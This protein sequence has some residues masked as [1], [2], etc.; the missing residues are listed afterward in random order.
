MANGLYA[1][2]LPVRVVAPGVS[3]ED[4]SPKGANKPKAEMKLA[5]W[6]AKEGAW[7]KRVGSCSIWL[8]NMQ[9][10]YPIVYL[11]SVRIHAHRLAWELARGQVPG[12]M[13]VKRTCGN[14]RCVRL[15][16]LKLVKHG[17]PGGWRARRER[18]LEQVGAGRPRG[19]GVPRKRGSTPRPA[20]KS[21]QRS[22]VAKADPRSLR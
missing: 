11:S 19:A 1:G 20:T 2:V 5:D 3:G 4:L 17:P 10:G 18:E 9:R 6:A 7:Y 21:G 14:A 16:H 12:G 22:P 13:D 8:K 15:A